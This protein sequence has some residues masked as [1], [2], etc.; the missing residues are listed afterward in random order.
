[1]ALALEVEQLIEQM[2]NARGD[3][4]VNLS[5]QVW[6]LIHTDLIQDANKLQQAHPNQK[7]IVTHIGVLCLKWKLPFKTCCNFLESSKFVRTGSYESLKNRKGFKVGEI[8][9]AAQNSGALDLIL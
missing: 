6:N 3:E 5:E 4:W 2:K 8:L 9:E 1:M 7:F